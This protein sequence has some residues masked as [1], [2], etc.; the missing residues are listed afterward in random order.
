MTAHSRLAPTLVD[1]IRK[2]LT[3]NALPG[4]TADFGRES[5]RDAAE[6]LAAV[7]AKRQAGELALRIESS[8]GRPQADADRD[9]QR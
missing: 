2:A 7:A 8:G 6:F 9:R 3:S 4:E 5:E 1:S